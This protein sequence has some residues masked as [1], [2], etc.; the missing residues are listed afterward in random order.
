MKNDK[1]LLACSV[2]CV[3]G[4]GCVETTAMSREHSGARAEEASG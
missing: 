4:S 3:R 1:S 2:A